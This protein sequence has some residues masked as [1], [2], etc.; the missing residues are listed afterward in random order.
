MNNN[1]VSHG[2]DYKLG[3]GVDSSFGTVFFLINL[4]RMLAHELIIY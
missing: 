1:I 4:A 2:Y 3:R